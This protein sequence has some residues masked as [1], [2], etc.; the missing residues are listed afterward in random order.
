MEQIFRHGW[1]VMLVLIGLVLVAMA[2]SGPEAARHE[3]L[4]AA[5][6]RPARVEPRATLGKTTQNVLQLAEALRQGGV[7]ASDANAAEPAQGLEAYAKAYRS[8]VAKGGAIAVEQ[9]MKLHEAEHGKLPA[10]HEEFMKWIIAPGS[11][12]EIRLPLL[13]Y[14]QEY[15]FDAEAK[16]LVV[17][18][19][20][21]KRQQRREE[22]T[23][24]A[25]L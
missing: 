22:T 3:A 2:F 16:K 1:K 9:K 5:P 14:Y 21:A 17:V 20:P 13:P 8:T 24:A 4:V 10:T 7:L 15:A 18:E 19:F 23:G 25:G 11:P 12:D 6:E